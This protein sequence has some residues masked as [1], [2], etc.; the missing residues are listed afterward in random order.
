MF[1]AKA[2]PEPSTVAFLALDIAILIA[3]CR[4]RKKSSKPQGEP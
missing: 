1:E 2:I 4:R 3:A